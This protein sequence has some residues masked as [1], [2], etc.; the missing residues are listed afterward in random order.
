MLGSFKDVFILSAP[1]KI[2]NPSVLQQLFIDKSK[3]LRSV[4][5]GDSIIRTELSEVTSIYW[6]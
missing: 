5:I 1:F 6:R 2:L 4:N 3:K